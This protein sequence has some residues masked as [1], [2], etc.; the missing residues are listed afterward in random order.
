MYDK[1]P[2]IQGKYSMFISWSQ[3]RT[4]QNPPFISLVLMNHNI[5]DQKLNK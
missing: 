1:V 2:Y 3:A 4:E 5:S